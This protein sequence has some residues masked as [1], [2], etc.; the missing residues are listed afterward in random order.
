[1]CIRV[2][3][4]QEEQ[5]DSELR[6]SLRMDEVVFDA[7]GRTRSLLMPHDA[8]GSIGAVGGGFDEDS[9]IE[10]EEEEEEEY[11]DEDT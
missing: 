1:M 3:I 9:M 8:D 11:A 7:W 2:R 5:C 4:W 10:E 6:E